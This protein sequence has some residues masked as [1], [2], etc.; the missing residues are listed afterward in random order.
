LGY[1]LINL[2]AF[3]EGSTLPPQLEALHKDD[4]IVIIDGTLSLSKLTSRVI[5]L[6]G[7]LIIPALRL[8]RF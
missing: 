4:E 6:S 8:L 2:T 5:V 3:R 1:Y 7:L